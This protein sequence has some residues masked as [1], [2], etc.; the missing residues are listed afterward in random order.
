MIPPCKDGR[1]KGA[2]PPLH[3]CHS[4]RKHTHTNTF[5]HIAASIAPLSLSLSQG[6]RKT[7][8]IGFV[9]AKEILSHHPSPRPPSHALKCAR[10][11]AFLFYFPPFV[12]SCY[13]HVKAAPTTAKSSQSRPSA[14]SHSV[15]CAYMCMGVRGASLSRAAW[16][17]RYVAGRLM[18]GGGTALTWCRRCRTCSRR[19][20]SSSSS[21]MCSSRSL[22]RIKLMK[23]FLLTKPSNLE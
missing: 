22:A 11:S 18:A 10:L 21:S 9:A 6:H 12:Q 7:E 4:Q 15:G 17:T 20:R 5:A 23:S 2:A 1:R 3:S 8:D 19:S 14:S 13:M 16:R